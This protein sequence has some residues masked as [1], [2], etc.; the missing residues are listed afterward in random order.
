MK[1]PQRPFRSVAWNCQFQNKKFLTGIFV[2]STTNYAR[3]TFHNSAAITG[4]L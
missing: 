2:N 1:Q 4:L 3:L